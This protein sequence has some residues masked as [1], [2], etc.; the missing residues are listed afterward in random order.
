[1]PGR[2]VFT[3]IVDP[4]KEL[5]GRLLLKNLAVTT[6]FCL[7]MLTFLYYD[8]FV[9]RRTNMVVGAA[10]RATCFTDSVVI[11]GSREEKRKRGAN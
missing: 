4:T 11:A 1:V 7:V 2:C 9:Q 10:A 6:A 5:E 3:F 8:C